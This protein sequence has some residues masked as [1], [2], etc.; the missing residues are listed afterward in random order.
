MQVLCPYYVKDNMKAML[1]Q[2][3]WS[4]LSNL[5]SVEHRVSSLLHLTVSHPR[6]HLSW[7]RTPRKD[8]THCYM[9]SGLLFNETKQKTPGTTPPKYQ[10][11][12]L[13]HQYRPPLQVHGQAEK[14]PTST[15]YREP[16]LLENLIEPEKH[17]QLE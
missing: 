12:S 9:C 15:P 7:V 10:D 5:S 1:H 16:Q 14:T 11:T 8:V 4:Y 3:V 13:S 2:D 17:E 6:R